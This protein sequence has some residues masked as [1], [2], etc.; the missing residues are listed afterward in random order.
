MLLGEGADE[1]GVVLRGD[2]GDGCEAEGYVNET[3]SNATPRRAPVAFGC[4]GFGSGGMASTSSSRSMLARAS[5][6]CA[7]IAPSSASGEKMAKE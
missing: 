4:S 7:M 3:P 2:E 1:D 5:W 6:Y